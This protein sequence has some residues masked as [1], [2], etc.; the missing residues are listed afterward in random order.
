M[1]RILGIVSLALPLLG[2]APKSQVF[3]GVITE[4]MCSRNHA[5]MGKVNSDAQC[6]IDC[7]K[8]SKSVRYALHDG[9]N[10]YILSDQATPEKFAA[11]KVRVKGALYPKT[12]IIKVESIESVK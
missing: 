6:I 8:S 12:G 5:M 3:T 4:T 11:R 9:K 10:M 7:V 2:Q 1:K